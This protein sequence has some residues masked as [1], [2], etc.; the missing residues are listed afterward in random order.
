MHP[1]VALAAVTGV[2]DEVKGE[3]A[4][5]YVVLK[6]DTTVTGEGLIAHCRE[7]LAAYKIPRAVQF[8]DTV[9]ITASGKIVRRLLKD[10][11]DGT[12]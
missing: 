11:D 3:L 12:R 6:P 9:P 10:F 8:V 5:A 7:H 2:P 4:K 1:A